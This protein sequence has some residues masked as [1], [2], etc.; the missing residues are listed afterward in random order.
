MF[1]NLNAEALGISARS[2]E[3]IELAL[4]FGFR[5]LDLD[6]FD[7]ADRAK[8]SGLAH[9]RRLFDSAKLSLSQFQLP[10][11]LSAND[12]DFAKELARLE[13]L[14]PVAEQAGA[15]R[16]LTIVRPTS[17]ALSY[18]QNFERHRQR[19]ANLGELLAKHAIQ[20]AVGFNAAADGPVE[21]EYEFIRDPTAL[22][23]LLDLVGQDNVGM[24]VDIW[25]L[26]AAGASMAA[27]PRLKGDRVVSVFVADAPA[28]VPPES[29]TSTARLLP[30]ETGVIDTAAALT[31]LKAFEYK[32]PV[33]V[34]PHR[35][36]FEKL[37]RDAIIRKT[38]ESL[39]TVWK[40]AGVP[41]A[42]KR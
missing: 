17:D 38:T 11:D 16:A 36:R 7:F 14:A 29:L 8:T 19:L 20:L 40:A 26:H 6:L 12:A 37:S 27:L 33:T 3:L 4:S 41:V 39:D 18:H 1:K 30:N 34:V 35:G 42:A 28:D 25:Q 24:L 2:S 9:A 32:G 13:E 23:L 10:V 15:K 5:G 31:T 21:G 22:L